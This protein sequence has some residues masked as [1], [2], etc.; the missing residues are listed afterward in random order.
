MGNL[1]HTKRA[2]D[3]CKLTARNGSDSS[4]SNNVMRAMN[5]KKPWNRFIVSSSFCFQ[6]KLQYNKNS[7]FSMLKSSTSL[8]IGFLR[9]KALI[10]NKSLVIKNQLS[11]LSIVFYFI[12]LCSMPLSS[13]GGYCLMFVLQQW[14]FFWQNW[15]SET[16]HL[17]EKYVNL[18]NHILEWNFESKL[19]I[20]FNLN[21]FLNKY[22]F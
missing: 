20:S 18:L 6:L 7:A 16:R 12:F 5:R 21:L 11:H 8:L 14:Y 13:H 1:S 3:P 15:R 22:F 4:K 10:P 19:C 17:F 2:L 9:S